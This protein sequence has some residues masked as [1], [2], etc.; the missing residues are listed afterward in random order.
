MV[1]EAE[2]RKKPAGSQGVFF[3]CLDCDHHDLVSARAASTETGRCRRSMPGS[4]AESAAGGELACSPH[5]LFISC[6]SRSSRSNTGLRA[7]RSS[8]RACRRQRASMVEAPSI[9]RDFGGHQQEVLAGFVAAPARVDRLALK[10]KYGFNELPLRTSDFA[11]SQR[12][13][14]RAQQPIYAWCSRPA[15]GQHYAEYWA[16][17]PD[18]LQQPTCARS[19]AKL[20]TTAGRRQPSETHQP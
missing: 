16:I 14:R 3:T 15:V 11:H 9:E 20:W 5:I 7:A 6:S 10:R 17:F 4:G 2:R 18:E 19:L 8:C 1:T 12:C 13:D